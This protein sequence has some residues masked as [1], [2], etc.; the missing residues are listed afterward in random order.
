MTSTREHGA[1]WRQ[2]SRVRCRG[3]SPQALAGPRRRRRGVQ[4][5][6]RKAARES[7][8]PAGF[9]LAAGVG[10]TLFGVDRERVVVTNSRACRPRRSP[11]ASP[12]WL[13]CGRLHVARG[14]STPHEGAT[15]SGLRAALKD[16]R[17]VVFI[18]AI[19]TL[20]PRFSLLGIRVEG[21]G[22]PPR[23][24]AR[25]RESP[26]SSVGR[27]VVSPRATPRTE[28]SSI[29]ELSRMKPCR[30]SST[31]PGRNL[32]DRAAKRSPSGRPG[33]AALVCSSATSRR[34]RPSGN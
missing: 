34:V 28:G 17:A 29:G 14:V 18:G 32:D 26:A 10:A 21:S 5:M 7:R 20:A 3:A 23:K 2:L 15:I 8:R 13:A 4:P 22:A 19:G 27:I 33:G 25:G 31:R 30:C 9:T 24:G 6:I 1:T 16:T 11:G 12:R